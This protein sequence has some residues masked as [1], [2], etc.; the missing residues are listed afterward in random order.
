MKQNKKSDERISLISEIFN[1]IKLIKM[2]C[3]ESPFSKKA[4]KLRK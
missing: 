2:Y 1:N 4:N 3:W